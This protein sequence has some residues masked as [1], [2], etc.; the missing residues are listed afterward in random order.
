M[1]INEVNIKFA[2]KLGSK[3]KIKRKYKNSIAPFVP[4]ALV[5]GALMAEEHLNPN[6][7]TRKILRKKF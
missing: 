6:S 4:A 7:V 2:R 1:F 3:N 5:G